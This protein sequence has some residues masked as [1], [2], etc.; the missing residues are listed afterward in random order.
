M[1]V[2]LTPIEKFFKIQKGKIPRVNL[3][4]WRLTV[5]GNVEKTLVLTYDDLAAMPQVKLTEILE[6]Y[7]NSPGGPLMGVAEWEGVPVSN[8]LD[9]A[10]VKE[11][12]SSIL[13]HS[14][15]GYSTNHRLSYVE[16]ACVMLALKMNAE[17][18]PL[19][20]G[21]PVRLVA[22][23]LYGY[24]WAKWV[25]RVEVSENEKLGYWESRGY[26][27]GPYRGCKFYKA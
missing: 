6:C 21:Y 10:R 1:S 23:G 20:H 14:L 24:K 12:S 8:L 25:Y 26:P 11:K 4:D 3:E 5:D 7:D 27:S 17:P 15:D 19:E 9:L 13:F 16:N 18:L 22:P 2:S